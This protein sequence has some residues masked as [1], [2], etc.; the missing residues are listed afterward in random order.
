MNI[1]DTFRS[2]QVRRV[3]VE[4]NLKLANTV[5]MT[6]DFNDWDAEGIELS[7]DGKGTWRTIL[8]LPPGEYEYRLLVDGNWSDH[9]EAK[10]RV[11]NPF[12]SENCVL[13]VT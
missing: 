3:P 10:K 1:L 13:V 8:E 6:G 9:P 4:V 7:P 12:G 11:P 2:R 5:L